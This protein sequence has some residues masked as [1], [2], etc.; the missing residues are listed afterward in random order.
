MGLYTYRFADLMTGNM[1]AEL[2]LTGVTFDSRLNAAGSFKAD[3]SLSDP[4]LVLAKDPIGSTQPGRTA[5]W[6]DRDGTLV[7]GGILWTRFYDSEKEVL[8]LGGQ[9]FFSY[10]DHRYVNDKLTFTNV[11]QLSIAKQLFQYAQGQNGSF[12]KPGGNI[13]MAYESP[14]PTS[15]V[16]RTLAL[17]QYELKQLS[18]SVTDLSQADNGFDFAVDVQY[19][20]SGVP[21][22][23][24]NPAYPRRGRTAIQSGFVVELPGG[25]QKYTYSEDGTGLE[26]TAFAVGTGTGTAGLTSS[27]STAALI[28]AGYPLLEGVQSYKDVT[29]QARL[30]AHARADASAYSE[31]LTIAAVT[32][33]GSVDPVVGSYITG[34]D[35]RLRITDKRFNLG[36][37]ADG[38]LIGPGID[39][40]KRIVGY[41]V[42]PGDDTLELVQMSLGAALS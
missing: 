35:I 3:L 2:P 17:T 11:D 36:H 18:Q 7:W 15:P 4:T 14:Y 24:F 21:I 16:P 23:T 32:V 33:V 38:S 6:V 37:R 5:I 19:D 13:G 22:F 12:P 1:L 30:D 40:F 29:D 27:A 41:Q 20:G 28:D 31:P 8:T 34:D 42:T 39:T 10:F 9:D 26:V 25:I